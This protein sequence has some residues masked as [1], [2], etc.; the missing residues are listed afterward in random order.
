MTER[1][2]T[3]P[4]QVAHNGLSC[5]GRP[6]RVPVGK[7]TVR[8]VLRRHLR[9]EGRR[10]QDLC[11]PWQC[12]ANTIYNAFHDKRPFSPGHVDAAIKFLGLDDFDAAELRLLGAR[13]AGWNIDT[14]YLLES[15][16]G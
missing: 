5:G 3:L 4:R 10:M 15:R 11:G 9:E 6:I 8:Q 2:R 16:D 12:K 14:Q 1:K 7:A 13:E